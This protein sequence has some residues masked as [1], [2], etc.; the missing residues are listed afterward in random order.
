MKE[1]KINYYNAE[2]NINYQFIFIQ[3]FM[4]LIYF[5]KLNLNELFFKN[6]KYFETRK[7]RFKD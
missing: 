3:V 5:I 1:S 2:H 4:I 7:R 6:N